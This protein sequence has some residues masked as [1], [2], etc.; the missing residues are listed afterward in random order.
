MALT[1]IFFPAFNKATAKHRRLLLPFAAGIAIG[2]VFLYLLPK[3]SDYTG[4]I[5]NNDEGSWEFAHYRLYL[6]A[7]V[8]FLAY[9]A[10]DRLST[11]DHPN[12]RRV[13]LIQ[14][15]GFCLYNILIGYIAY[16]LPRFGVLPY[17]F[18]TLAMC[19]HF[20]GVDHQL[21]HRQEA[22]YD[23]YLRW[24]IAASVLAGW[25]ISL[26]FEFPKEFLMSAAAF[27]SGGIIMNVMIAELPDKREGR[28]APLMAGVFFFLV[29]VISMRSLPRVSV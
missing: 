10:I 26:F 8:G 21:R 17:V 22:A 1:H 3:L 18:G 6:L 7:L 19:A 28:L 27:L 11:I 29:I 20:I 24:L 5:V 14:G 25:G 23:R 13:P 2:Y 12:V 9:L 4:L 16:S 15:A